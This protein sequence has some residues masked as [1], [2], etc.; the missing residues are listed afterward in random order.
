MKW[1]IPSLEELEDAIE[2]VIVEV[3]ENGVIAV[4]KVSHNDFDIILMN[5]VK[6]F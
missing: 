3:A 6:Y 1:D 5:L 4:E 2:D